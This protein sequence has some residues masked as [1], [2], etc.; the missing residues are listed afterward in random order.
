MLKVAETNGYDIYELSQS[1]CRKNYLVYP[2]FS[3]Y[4]HGDTEIE[5]TQTETLEEAVEWCES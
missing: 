1:E 3:V 5:E 4:M 2:C